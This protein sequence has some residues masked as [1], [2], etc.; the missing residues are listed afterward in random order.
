MIEFVICE[1][2]KIFRQRTVRIIEKIIMKRKFKYEI[3]EYDDYNQKFK[4]TELNKDFHVKIYILDIETPTSNGL[5]IAKLIRSKDIDSYIIFLTSHNEL[6]EFTLKKDLFFQAFINKTT[7]FEDRLKNTVERI[8]DKNYRR[9]GIIIETK[10]ATF[11]FKLSEILYIE[12][13]VNSRKTIIHTEIGQ[14]V[15]NKPIVYFLNVLDE[16]FAQTHKSCIV[17]KDKI[18]LIDKKDNKIVFKNG[19]SISLLSLLYRKEIL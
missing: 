19:E 7:D 15:V 13:D 14:Y 17:N 6:A 11:Q 5:E 2:N 9:N 16:R 4:N 18:R 8:L 12:K 3:R 1:D 10:E